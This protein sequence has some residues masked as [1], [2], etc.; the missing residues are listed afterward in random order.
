M[1]RRWIVVALLFAG[2]VI[3]YVDR[4]SLGLLKP[5]ISADL[6]WTNSDFAN[7]VLSFQGAY[8]ISYLVFGRF[9]DRVGARFGLAAAFAIWSVAQVCTAGARS[10]GQFQIARA[11]L[12]LGEAGAFP[13]AIKAIAAW[14]PQKERAFANGLF[15]AG[16]NV[17]AIVT[18]L[19]VPA[20]TLAWGWRAAFVATG[21]MGLIWLPI[22]L[23]LFR[24]PRQ[25]SAISADELAWIEQDPPQ[26]VERI[27][28]RRLIGLRQ[29]W[30]YALAKFMT[31]PV[32]G[33]FLVW[34]PDF[35]SRRYKLDLK[36]FGPPLIVIYLMSDFGSVAG[37]WLSSSLIR[38]G[39]SVNAARK[40]TLLVCAL[41]ALP[42][43]MAWQA[44]SV[45]GAVA[46]IGLATA[47]HQGFSATLYALPADLVPRAGVGSVVGLGG[48][49]GAM[50]GMLMSKYTGWTLDHD[51]GYAPVFAIAG[52]TYLC[53]L[54]VVHLLSP[55]LAP[56]QIPATPATGP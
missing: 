47:A 33:M 8:A 39:W 52:G 48:M 54:L 1:P 9:V 19:I 42:V 44:S 16:T 28:L 14:F 37:G 55:R 12:G 20:I 36:T 32:W 10:L 26:P 31:D 21:L 7:V 34:L 3:N 2:M 56:A 25:T 4:Q 38:R 49:L 50:G 27:G 41:C 40:T 29:T 11:V 15:N 51:R 23:I 35:L 13:G 53:A 45:W 43:T 30:T 5:T 24:T 17:G 46:L 18:P 22:W 6:G